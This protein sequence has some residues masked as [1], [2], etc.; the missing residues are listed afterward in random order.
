MTLS[1][2]SAL[3]KV[4]FSYVFCKSNL[5]SCGI[6]LP[7]FNRFTEIKP[8][9]TAKAVVPIYI[10]IVLPP[11]RLNFF[12]SDKED[13]PVT[14]EHSTKG[15][16]TSF[17]KLMKITPNGA[18]QFDVKFPNPFFVFDNQNIYS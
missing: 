6:L 7:G 3:L 11:I 2:T 12:I 10:N 16:A 15:I 4:S 17:N 1:A 5:N 8:I 18:I 9:E 13:T 14:K